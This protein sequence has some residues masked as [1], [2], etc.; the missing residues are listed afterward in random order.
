[1]LITVCRLHD[2]RPD[3]H[4]VIVALESAGVPAS[5]SSVI[6]NDCDTWYRGPR[7]PL[8][9]LRPGRWYYGS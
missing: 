3:A 6:S 2:S 4:P 8:S 5:D 7:R 1:M 9:P